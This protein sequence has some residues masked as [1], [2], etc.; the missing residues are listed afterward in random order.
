MF[1]QMDVDTMLAK[2]LLADMGLVGAAQQQQGKGGLTADGLKEA[3]AAATGKGQSS[4]AMAK[5]R[6]MG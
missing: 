2:T 4:A 5:S 6:S 1:P 3:A